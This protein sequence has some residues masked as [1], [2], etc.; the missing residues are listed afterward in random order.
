MEA[1][2]DIFI[3]CAV[4]I[5]I[6]FWFGWHFRGITMMAMFSDDPQKVIDILERIKKINEEE[7][8]SAKLLKAVGT[9]VEPELVNGQWYAYTKDTNQFVGQ[10]STIQEALDQAKTRFPGK[11]FWCNDPEKSN[12]SS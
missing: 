8:L 3:I 11:T 6:G 7:R 1:I 10:G 2:L 9:E 5:G 12:Q 4:M